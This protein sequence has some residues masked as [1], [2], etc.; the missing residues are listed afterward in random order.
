MLGWFRHWARR[1]LVPGGLVLTLVAA[2]LLHA[3]DMRS[4]RTRLAEGVEVLPTRHGPVAFLR[5]GE[6]PA[7]LVIHGAGGGHDQGRLIADAYLGPGFSVVAPSRFGYP[8]SPLPPDAS[9]EAQAE[10]LADLLDGLGHDRVMMLAMS[11]G[12]PPALQFA[13]LHPERTEAL[14]LV[15]AAP[16]TPLGLGDQALPVPGWAY[17]LLFAGDLPFWL[18]AR[19]RPR[20]LLELFDADPGVH[21]PASAE[22]AAFVDALTASF[23]PATARKAGL[24][25]EV[26][27]VDPHATPL[28]GAIGAP[29]LVVH[30]RDDA[31]APFATARFLADSLPGA[32]LVVFD[33]GGHLLIGHMAETRARVRAHFA[34][35]RGD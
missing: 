5:W 16:F 19:L 30:A 23:L 11:G 8:G 7:V 1:A 2:G 18:L 13:R 29:T 20:M 4:A 9:T 35:H 17:E 12:V 21:P 25:N 32:S 33:R 3:S 24:G 10:A 28:P 34:R 22:E 31:L 26:A 15:S 27:A 6:G 14:A